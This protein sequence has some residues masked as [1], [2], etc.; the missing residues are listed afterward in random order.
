MKLIIAFSVL[1]LALC[2]IRY[3]DLI[4]SFD[5]SLDEQVQRC[6]QHAHCNPLYISLHCNTH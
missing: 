1:C 5:K 3:Y 2:I 6:T 4:S